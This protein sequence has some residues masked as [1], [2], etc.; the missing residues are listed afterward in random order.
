MREA[1]FSRLD[2][3]SRARADD[4]IERDDVG[5]VRGDCDQ[6]E[7]V[8]QILLDVWVG[9]D[10]RRGEKC[11]H[12]AKAH[13]NQSSFSGIAS[14][15]SVSHYYR[16]HPAVDI[17][18]VA[19]NITGGVAR[20][21][22]DRGGDVL[23]PADSFEWYGFRDFGFLFIGE[24]SGHVGFYKARGN[25]VHRDVSRCKLLGERFGQS[26]ESGFGGAMVAW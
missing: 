16:I 20:K 17:E 8:R 26:D 14:E 19:G 13:R 1:G 15:L 24:G 22:S 7:P 9:E 2:F 21:E 6:A 18:H 11:T 23:G 4:D 5:I 3:V 25:R 10:F 12:G